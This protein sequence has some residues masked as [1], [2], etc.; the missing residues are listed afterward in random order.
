MRYGARP[1]AAWAL[2]APSSPEMEAAGS[3][4]F[5]ES[6]TPCFPMRCYGPSL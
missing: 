4:R 3:P 5:G 2:W 6:C 1:G